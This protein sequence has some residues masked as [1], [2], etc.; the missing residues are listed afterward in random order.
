MKHIV[1]RT[2]PHFFQAL[3]RRILLSWLLAAGAEYLLLPASSRPL[4]SLTGLASMSLSR[5]LLL[6]VFF[7]FFFS[8]LFRLFRCER[9]ERF[10]TAAAFAV[11]AVFALQ[12][13]F[14]PAFFCGCLLIFIV[15]IVYALFGQAHYTAASAVPVRERKI[16]LWITAGLSL[17]F[18]LFVSLWTVCR[19]Y[20]FCVPS[21][22][23]G[24]FSQMFYSM[25][26]TGL[27][28]TTIE[29]D[30]PLS[31]FQV[32]VS[33][34]CYLLL[35]FYFLA[36]TPSV[37]QILQ[38]AVITSAVLP[39]WKLGRL[40]G[41]SPFQRF[42][43]CAL[44]LLFPSY[45]GGTSYDFHENAFLT[46]LLLWLFYGIDK[47]ST[48][49]TVIFALL[50]LTVKED[51]AVYTAVIA[52]WLI[53]KAL[54]DCSPDRRRMLLTGCLLLT[55]SVLWF[56]LVT[57][58]LANAGDGVMSYRY[59][60][61]MYD[62]SDSLLT[63]IKAVLLCPLKVIYE[64]TEHQ[65]LYFIAMT[66]LPLLG[67]WLLTRHYERLILLIPYILI[68]LMSDYSYQHN[69][70]F[71]Y[72]FGSFACLIYLVLL[73]TADWKIRWKKTLAFFC[74]AAAAAVCFSLTVVPK[75]VS[76]PDKYISHCGYYRQLRDTLSL[77]P[78]DAS[79][80]ATTFYTTC[81]SQ[82]DILYD[83]RYS[84]EEHLLSTEYVVLDPS[85]QNDY[86]QYQTK[87]ENGYLNLVSLLEKN[88]YTVFAELGKSLIIYRHI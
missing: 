76:Y 78:Q 7:M 80:T 32:H 5:M 68:N 13:S 42:L 3:L 4:D 16:F 56:L 43:L 40:H 19:V 29:R 60:N 14:S 25:K 66:L 20:S 26:T 83:V 63:V 2:D 54:T 11:P 79:V 59:K 75:A 33:P 37:L 45:S 64:C 65:N 53:A 18:F 28:V 36:P 52:L 69:I 57:G 10:L 48:L 9:T 47:K 23:F 30:G 82:R 39:L 72:T 49:L 50:T 87:D 22:D 73:N 61:F 44:L 17:L 55:A 74:A 81:L 31:H 24:I 70:F 84:S 86:K 6:F 62:G 88:G 21:F 58:Y 41:L 34:V 27:P 15:L 46:P 38:A 67:L 12:T 51:A 1:L 8:V 77:I 71:Q 35:P 85:L